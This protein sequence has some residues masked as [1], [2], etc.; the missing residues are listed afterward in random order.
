MKLMQQW[1]WKIFGILCLIYTF[2]GGLLIPLSPGIIQVQPESVNVGETTRI[3]VWGY[4]TEFSLADGPI[5]VY[6]RKGPAHL[7]A[8]LVNMEDDNHLWAEFTIP[9]ELNQDKL[10]N[11]ALDIVVHDKHDGTIALRNALLVKSDNREPLDVA[12]LDCDKTIPVEKAE[13]FGFPYREILHESIRNL[14][15][16]VPMWFCMVALLFAAFINSIMFL[17]NGNMK[18]DIYAEAGV[19]VG[20]VFGI[21]GLI[22]GMIWATYTWGSP[23][24]NDPKLNGAAIAMMI[25]FAYVILRGSITDEIRRAKVAAVYNIFAFVIYITFI[26]IFPRLSDSLHPGNGGNPAFSSYDLDNTLRMFFYP[27]VMGWC[28]LGFWLASLKIR[29]KFA[30]L[31]LQ[32]ID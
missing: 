32:D 7:C 30:L 20:V 27:A 19:Q 3:R 13:N 28:I 24:P 22:T 9:Y 11:Q 17:N 6:L 26:F 25:Y 12:P 4:N 21:L 29:Y 18:H 15:F 1:W 16:H 31:K 23:W 5:S 14:F 2:A 10:D 8:K